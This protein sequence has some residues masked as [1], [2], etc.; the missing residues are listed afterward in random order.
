MRQAKA[1]AA[2]SRRKLLGRT[3]VIA[4]AVITGA[5]VGAHPVQAAP[6]TPNFGALIDDY[7]AGDFQ[8]TC[9][10]TARP[11]VVDFRD[12]LLASYP[13]TADW[14][15]VRD[16]SV[17]G[18]SE[19]KEGR[20]LDWGVSS[21]SQMAIAN[22]ALN[23][24]MATDKYGNAHAL[25]R[26]FGI[27][28]IVWN[29]KI[30]RAYN[31]GAGWQDYSCDGTVTDCHQ[32]HMHFSFS[33]A[34]ADRQTSWWAGGSFGKQTVGYYRPSTAQYNLRNSNTAGSP[35]LSFT[36][37]PTNRVPVAGDWNADGK[38]T[39]GYYQ[40]SDGSWHLR[41]TNNGGGDDLSFTYGPPNM[42]P[43]VGDWNNDGKTTVGYY[44][45][46][47]ATFHL[48]NTNNAGGDDASFA[49]G[50]TNMRPVAGDWNNDGKTT[51]G[52]YNPGNATWHLRNTN[53][54]GGDDASF[55]YGPTNMTPIAGDWN[56]DGKS[57]IGYYNPG[58]AT[59]H[60][61]NTN[62]AGGDDASFVYGP[63]GSKPIVGDWNKA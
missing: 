42:V 50:P 29:K 9:S 31:S 43:I 5:S 25:I 19:H 47:N 23:W 3:G 59:W 17:G 60:L 10:P 14:G 54:A 32:D 22:D 8:D 13:G 12:I 44:N 2:R 30:W 49:Y 46:A 6:A 52:Y 55:A 39:I 56:A 7:A 11:G 38:T 18:R 45:P 26:R 51:I 21:F 37:G 48:R 24:L 41:N 63:T 36:Y 4:A 62:N 34:G 53:N 57:T 16:C 58:N 1:V 61:R 33:W 27:M 40:P 28:Y 20:A 15:I 35:D